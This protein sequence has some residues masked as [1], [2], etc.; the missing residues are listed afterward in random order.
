MND[1]CIPN[2]G[3]RERRRRLIIGIAMFAIA[4]AVA[5]MLIV[6]DAPKV[7]RVFVLLPSWVGALG[8]VQVKEKTCVAL[9]ARGMRNMDS[10]DERITDAIEL[11]HVKAQSRRVHLQAATL[12]VALTALVLVWR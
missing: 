8:V 7:W 6:S 1:A 4:A 10:G 5:T 3:P 11:D 12:A 2:I 9:A